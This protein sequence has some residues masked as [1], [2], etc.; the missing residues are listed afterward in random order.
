VLPEDASTGTD[1]VQIPETFHEAVVMWVV[2]YGLLRDRDYTGAYAMHRN[3]ETFMDTTV[4]EHDLLTEEM[5]GGVEVYGY[6]YY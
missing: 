4:S 5:D 2:W 3:L 1:V 6:D